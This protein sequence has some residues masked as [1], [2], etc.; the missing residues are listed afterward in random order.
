MPIQSN[1]LLAPGAGDLASLGTVGHRHYPTVPDQM[2]AGHIEVR[3][4]DSE[5]ISTESRARA[6]LPESNAPAH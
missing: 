5:R 2:T 3:D 1:P 4:A 6:V